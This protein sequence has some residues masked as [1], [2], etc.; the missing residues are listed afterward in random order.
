MPLALL[1]L[2]VVS[3]VESTTRY[4]SHFTTA[5]GV[6]KNGVFWP[7]KSTKAMQASGSIPRKRPGRSFV[8]ESE[9][10]R[11][12]N[13]LLRELKGVPRQLI[14]RLLRQGKIRLNGNKAAPHTKVAA[15]DRLQVPDIRTGERSDMPLK[16]PVLPRVIFESDDFLVLDKSAGY[17]VHGGSGLSHGLIEA[18]RQKLSM[19]GLELAHR[20]DK[21]TSGLLVLAKTRRGLRG[22]H[23]QLRS[24]EVKKTY[25]ALVLGTWSKQNSTINLPLRKVPAAKGQRRS[26]V[27]ADG[28]KS[29][30]RCKCL[31]Q[32]AKG[33]AVQVDLVTGRTH[34]ARVH[35]SAVGNPILGDARYGDHEVNAR[36]KKDGCRGLMLHARR[37]EFRQPGDDKTLVL[38]SELPGHFDAG[39]KWLGE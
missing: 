23:E 32:L 10:Q 19:P 8:V 26:V 18:A 4:G 30:T 9:G 36:A 3:K 11:V 25:T 1:V 15:G 34:Q 27:D 39:K 6:V 28:A 35:L 38:H 7:M 20:L 29:V 24:G 22:F 33:A 14:Y 31:A 16:N 37:L 2:D 21:D 17:A 12:D 5:A 13:Y